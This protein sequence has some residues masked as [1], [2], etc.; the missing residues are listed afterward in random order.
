MDAGSGSE[1]HR[2]GP[3]GPQ[4]LGSYLRDHLA[5]A[6]AGLELARR[7]RDHAP[8]AAAR[9]ELDAL[10]REVGEDRET[11]LGL[12]HGLGVRPDPVRQGLA[13]LAE[14]AT[15]VRMAPPFAAGREL[16]RLLELEA[17]AIGVEGKRAL[18][19]ALRQTLA[20]SP[21]ISGVPLSELSARAG[22]QREL[23]ERHRLEAAA[24]AFGRHA[25]GAPPATGPSSPPDST[26]PTDR[27]P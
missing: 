7:C 19:N 4:Q 18:W 14:L 27:L 24:G 25:G 9:A 13:R 11:L 12:M 17:L 26:T 3:Q 5:G 20:G 6:T 2:E 22:R 16:G 21:L 10:A 8:G 23:L 15:R 1:H